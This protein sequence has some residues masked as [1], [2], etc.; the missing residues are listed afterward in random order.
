[1]IVDLFTATGGG[2][3]G[4]GCGNLAG[5]EL[6]RGSSL[7]DRVASSGPVIAGDWTGDGP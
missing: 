7:A 2:R 3:G 5:I 4:S 6:G 1:M